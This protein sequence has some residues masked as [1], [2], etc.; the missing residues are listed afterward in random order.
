MGYFIVLMMVVSFLSM[1][2][3]ITYWLRGGKDYEDAVLSR[4]RRING[5]GNYRIAW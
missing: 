2:L 4:A 5:V 3:F 1:G